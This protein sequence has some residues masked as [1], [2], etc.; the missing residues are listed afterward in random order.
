MLKLEGRGRFP[1]PTV[2]ELFD[3]LHDATIFL[4]FDL[5]VGYHQIRLAPIDVHKT[6]FWTIDGHFEFLVTPFGLMN[7][8]ST[9]CLYAK[10]SKYLF[11]AFSVDYLGHTI[12]AARLAVDSTKLEAIANWVVPTSF[13][14]LCIFLG[15]IGA[16]LTFFSKKKFDHLQVASAYEREMSAIMDVVFQT[17]AQHKWFSKLLGFDYKVIYTPGRKTWWLTPYRATPALGLLCYSRS[18]PSPH[19]FWLIFAHFIRRIRRVNLSCK[20][21]AAHPLLNWSFMI[22]MVLFSLMASYLSLNNLGLVLS[23][24]RNS[25]ALLL[26]DTPAYAPPLVIC[27]PHFIRLKCALMFTNSSKAVLFASITNT[28]L[29]GHW[30]SSPTADS[31]PSLGGLEFLFIRLANRNRTPPGFPLTNLLPP[32]RSLTLGQ[33][34]FGAPGIDTAQRHYRLHTQNGLQNLDGKLLLEA[35]N[36]IWADY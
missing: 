8:F 5:Y 34:H 3:E 28:S 29:T 16:T 18:P 12:S 26:G 1:I 15:V 24:S 11:G 33:G 10:L 25:T 13:T 9:Y 20:A 19:L 22:F 32:S 23:S 21:F 17:L 35:P 4:K 6:T 14:S 36:Y 30:S 2:D 27:L 31:Q 7:V